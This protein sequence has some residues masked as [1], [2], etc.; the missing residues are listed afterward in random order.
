MTHFSQP[1][2]ANS[3]PPTRQSAYR[4]R[5]TIQ[6]LLRLWCFG[7]FSQEILP[8]LELDWVNLHKK[9]DGTLPPIAYVHGEVFGAGGLKTVPDNPRGSRSKSIEN[10][11]KGR[12]QW[13]TK[14]LIGRMF[15]TRPR[16]EPTTYQ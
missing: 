2:V 16:Y 6:R 1:E 14:D 9:E 12:G 15:V 8:L 11:C 3:A 5:R 4:P 10:R 13:N 7:Q